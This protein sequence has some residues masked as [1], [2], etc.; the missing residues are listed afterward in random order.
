VV[1]AVKAKTLTGEPVTVEKERHINS[2]DA[3][4]Q[5]TPA[6]DISK[7]AYVADSNALA[8]NSSHEENN[9]NNYEIEV[10]FTKLTNF[11]QTAPPHTLSI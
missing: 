1:D 8:L 7:Q 9:P 6:V 4:R 11:S 3:S 10:S 2:D 5:Q